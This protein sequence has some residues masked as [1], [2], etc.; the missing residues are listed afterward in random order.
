MFAQ[1]TCDKI[2]LRLEIKLKS[3]RTGK[4]SLWRSFPL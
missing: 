3:N 1:E 4:F 2:K